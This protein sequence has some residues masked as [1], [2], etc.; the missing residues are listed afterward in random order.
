MQTCGGGM[1]FEKILL[2]QCTFSKFDKY[3]SGPWN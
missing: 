1:K 2:A 3:L